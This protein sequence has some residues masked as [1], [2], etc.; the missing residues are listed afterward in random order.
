MQLTQG[1]DV[2]IDMR[3]EDLSQG[4]SS[5]ASLVNT[6]STSARAPPPGLS[7]EMS[8]ALQALDDHLD[9]VPSSMGKGGETGRVS[10]TSGI[11][12]ARKLSDTVKRPTWPKYGAARQETDRTSFS[13]REEINSRR[14]H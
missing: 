2:S 5:G 14:D 11:D 9:R 6:R 8:G 3:K 13:L 7:F 4:Y 10:Q 1:T 12:D